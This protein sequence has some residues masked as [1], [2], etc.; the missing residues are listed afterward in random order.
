MVQKQSVAPSAKSAGAASTG[1]PGKRQATIMSFF[2]APAQPASK[3]NEAKKSNNADENQKPREDPKEGGKEKGTSPPTAHSRSVAPKEPPHTRPTCEGMTSKS[4]PPPPPA[5]S[6][7]AAEG[8]GRPSPSTRK[9]PRGLSSSSSPSASAA[10]SKQETK[11]ADSGKE[12]PEKQ[13]QPKEKEKERGRLKRNAGMRA[14]FDDSD[15]EEETANG[16]GE[17]EGSS[18]RESGV[19]PR[20]QA[21]RSTSEDKKQ[22]PAQEKETAAQKKNNK[23]KKTET[24]ESSEEEEEASASSESEYEDSESSSSSSDSSDDD[25]DESMGADSEDEW[26]NFG[27]GGGAKKAKEKKKS[28]PKAKKDS[29][30]A[31]ASS[32]KKVASGGNSNKR[33]RQEEEKEKQAGGAN[34]KGKGKAAP[35]HAFPIFAQAAAAAQRRAETPTRPKAPRFSSSSA[36]VQKT[37]VSL[38]DLACSQRQRRQETEETAGA[39]PAAPSAETETGHAAAL[40]SAEPVEEAEKENSDANSRQTDTQKERETKGEG[41]KPRR[42]SLS[43]DRDATETGDPKEETGEK[44]LQSAPAASEET[45]PRPERRPLQLSSDSAQKSSAKAKQKREVNKAK[46][47]D[48]TE[49]ENALRQKLLNTKA[50]QNCRVFAEYVEHFYGVG[51]SFKF[52]PWMEPSKIK[53]K[54]GRRPDGDEKAQSEYDFRTLWVPRDEKAAKILMNGAT[55]PHFTPAMA[56]YWEVKSEH[57]DKVVFFK[58]GKFYELFYVDACIAQRALD[59]KWMGSDE[60]PHV[61]FPEQSLHAYAEGLVRHGYKVVVV[62]QMETPKQLEERNAKAKTGQKS[63]AVKRDVCEVYSQG[64]LEH[65]SMLSPDSRFLLALFFEETARGLHGSSSAVQMEGEGGGLRTT[66]LSP[67]E[68]GE[69]EGDSGG[70]SAS[71]HSGSGRAFAFC[72]I[73]VAASVVQ[74]GRQEDCETRSGLS[75]LLAQTT[76][77]EVLVGSQ[78]VPSDVTKMIRTL[79]FS[80]LVTAIPSESINPMAAQATIDTYFAPDGT[81]NPADA[82]KKGAKRKTPAVIE[83]LSER[84]ESVTC[85]LGLSLGYLQEALQDEKVTKFGKFEEH[86]P[87]DR[88][89]MILDAAALS[90]LEILVTQDGSDKHSLL[91]HL[92]HCSTPLGKRLLRRWLCA[93]LLDE[94][95][96]KKRLDAVE[97]LFENSD[98][99]GRLRKQLQRMPVTDLERSVARVVK[100]CMQHTRAKQAI[101]FEDVGE[102]QLRDF[103]SVLNALV[104]VSEVV[105]LDADEVKEAEGEG[106]KEGGFPARLKALRTLQKDGGLF[107]DLISFCEDLKRHLA[108]EEGEKG[109]KKLVPA[110][111]ADER[112][113]GL[114]KE[115]QGVRD[116]LDKCLKEVK[117]RHKLRD[118]KFVHM[119]FRYEIQC[120]DSVPSS[121]LKT[122][123]VTS[124]V[125]GYVRFH[126]DEVKELVEELEELEESLKESHAPFMASLLGKF[127]ARTDFVDAA[128]RIVAEL[129]VLCSLAT[130]AA[131]A[132]GPVCRPEFVPFEKGAKGTGKSGCVLELRECRHP[133]A[134]ALMPPGA[135]IPNDMFLN[136]EGVN[137][138]T[139]LLTGP[140]MGGKSTVLRQT[141][142]AVVMAQAGCFV[143]ASK[144]RL[145][146]VDRIFTRIGASDSLLEGKSAFLVELEETSTMLNE[147]TERSLAVLDELGRGTSTFDGTAIAMASLRHLAERIQCRS[148][149]STHFHLLPPEFETDEA[150]GEGGGVVA[151]F[152]MAAEVDESSHS[153]TFLYKVSKGVCPRSHGMHVARVAGIPESVLTSAQKKSD[154]LERA[155]NA[156]QE[157]AKIRSRG[158][159]LLEA[160]KHDDGKEKQQEGEVP[161]SE[162]AET[163]GVSRMRRMFEASRARLQKA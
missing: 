163:E 45:A 27:K 154:Q 135:F 76:P 127:A 29:G 33:P 129:D 141:C 58:V 53:D 138:G 2:K 42:A 92:N 100:H 152:H 88:R 30:K 59:L 94:R 114:K 156:I 52:P 48:K 1:K 14:L 95:A 101:Y 18:R 123:D 128:V 57:F 31:K 147:A 90:N 162:A 125:K 65:D 56:Q 3:G 6:A 61:G 93:P 81:E 161:G 41:E 19:P 144:C 25:S 103:V 11:K 82:A 78:N 37:A 10:A 84:F 109:G 47:S 66:E 17:E 148:L 85:C 142:L 149:F 160:L 157:L 67:E 8:E 130:A 105:V 39:T 104:F 110:A 80:P 60:K 7:P 83:K 131:S 15:E 150:A 73:D 87:A 28:E 140:N 151:N 5:S 107:P 4:L 120:A 96:L 116:R 77:A 134:A 50:A 119:K 155:A 32:S 20:K 158:R 62:E 132:G 106:E 136:C 55:A 71:T 145:T 98:A 86:C 51:K 40:S 115:I 153:V 64:T 34:G 113:D 72:L 99:A 89:H 137:M 69:A 16:K 26:D 63:K 97:W 139:A 91:G 79:P 143:H 12:P 9:S 124:S 117:D 118:C 68:E 122:V 49:K 35:L 44:Q 24:E 23:R 111:G 121:F 126:T 36:A 43:G 22:K 70:V 54:K 159:K 75:L 112:V 21:R 102:K 74:V 146:P 108:E 133:M 38:E 13:Q 46:S